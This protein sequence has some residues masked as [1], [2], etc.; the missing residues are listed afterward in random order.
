[1]R[2]ASVAAAPLLLATMV[3]PVSAF[4]AEN[5]DSFDSEMTSVT[6]TLSADEV[7]SHDITDTTEGQQYLKQQGTAD[8]R[9]YQ[10]PMRVYKAGD[11][12]FA[13]DA[14]APV[15]IVVG[16]NDNGDVVYDFQGVAMP[17]P[18]ASQSGFAVPGASYWSYNNS[19]TWVDNPA[20]G[21]WH[22]DGWWLINKAANPSCSG[23]TGHDYWRI[24]GKLRSSTI[25]GRT[26]GW[27]RTW[28]EFTRNGTWS[29]RQ[30]FES[31]EPAQ[32]Y[33]GVANQT[34]TIGFRTGIS[35]SLGVPPLSSGGSADLTYTGSMTQSSE[36][37]HPVVRADSVAQGGVQWCYYPLT[38]TYFNGTKIITTRE[39]AQMA[40][41]GTMGGWVWSTG[42]SHANTGCPT[43]L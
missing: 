10:S 41:G 31:N 34:R 8:L 14:T 13:T 3:T 11:H 16:T 23:C 32:S 15:H 2:T 29:A 9:L 20:G 5:T 7:R 4:A 37:W 21:D 24:T 33:A 27:N 12:L 28:L 39:N 36:N 40:A 22:R 17:A 1:M 19:G 30:S 6:R 25:T 18:E 43:Q 42:Q 35:V 38:S 26:F